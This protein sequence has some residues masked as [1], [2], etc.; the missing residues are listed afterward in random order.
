MVMNLGYQEYT[1]SHVLYC[2]HAQDRKWTNTLHGLLRICFLLRF[3]LRKPT[4]RDSPTLIRNWSSLIKSWTWIRLERSEINRSLGVIASGYTLD[5]NLLIQMLGNIALFCLSFVTSRSAARTFTVVN[6]CPFT[7]W[8]V[9]S[10]KLDWS[11]P[12]LTSI[13]PAVSIAEGAYSR[14]LW[15]VSQI[16]TDLSVG[17]NI[18]DQPTGFVSLGPVRSCACIKI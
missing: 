10:R 11:A 6:A 14:T 5:L 7:I 13:R 2:V 16:Y 8:Y 15:H 18:P 17:T 3:K 12:L 9:S 4:L 1:K